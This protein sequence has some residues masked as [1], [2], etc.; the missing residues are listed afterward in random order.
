[1]ISA[2]CGAA[3][4]AYAFD[5]AAYSIQSQGKTLADWEKAQAGINAGGGT[6]CGVALEWMTWQNERVEQIVMVTDEEENTPP[7]FKDAY[8][9]Y[10]NQNGVRPAVIFVKIGNAHN[11]L[12]RVCTELG[13][14]PNVFEFRGDYYALPNVIPM[15]SYPSLTELVMDVLNYPLPKRNLTPKPLS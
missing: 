14:A 4:Y 13:V 1:M 11:K 5:T 15:L 12:E 6:S 7:L 2:I 3:L 8:E 9:K 10:A